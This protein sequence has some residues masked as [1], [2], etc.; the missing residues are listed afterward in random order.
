MKAFIWPARNP[1]EAP[2]CAQLDARSWNVS[3][4][5]DGTKIVRPCA[6]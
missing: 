1:A 4:G 5:D 6:V 3:A 2:A